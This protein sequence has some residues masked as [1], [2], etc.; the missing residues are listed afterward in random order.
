MRVNPSDAT[1][2]P[3]GLDTCVVMPTYNERE[4]LERTIGLVLSNNPCADVL[5][6]D[7][8]SPDGTGELAERM[9]QTNTRIKVL[10]RPG[11]G[12]LGPAYTAG[13]AQ[14]LADGYALICEMDMD[15]SHRAVDLA[16]MLLSIR[17]HPDVSLV[18]GSR[19]VTGGSTPHWP[20]YRDAISRAGSWYA[21]TMLALPVH[22]MTAGFRVYRAAMLRQ[23]MRGF[24][25]QG[26]PANG[27]VFQ[28]DMTRRV[29]ALHGEIL[30]VPITFPER[31]HGDSKMSLSIVIEAMSKVSVWGLQR[32]FTA[33]F[34]SLR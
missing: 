11:K 23:V 12:G 17:Q 19:R 20:W 8:G 13:F 29:A 26:E 25:A 32:I 27:Y 24:D 4:N 14:A 15:G 7:D 10:H 28:I 3:H 6:V 9:A 1:A 30:E 21:S 2:V 31:V 5:V 18:I 34:E 33:A 16:A 22:D